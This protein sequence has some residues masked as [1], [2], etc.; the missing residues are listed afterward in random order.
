MNDLQSFYERLDAIP[1]TKWDSLA[2]KRIF[3]GHQSVGQN[4]I[5]GIKS[6]MDGYPAVR[7][8]IHQTSNPGDMGNAVFAHSPIGLN[9]DP[10]SKIDDFRT[11][12]ESGVGQIIDVAIFKFCFVDINRNTDVES[13]FNYYD[14]II[15]TLEHTYPRVRIITFTVPLTNMPTGIKPLIK[16]TLG[17]MPRY[18]EDNKKRNIFN[19]RLRTRFGKSVFDIA[20][21]EATLTEGKK[22]SFRDGNK[23]YDLLN[24]TYTSDGGH[25]NMLGRQIVAIDLLLYLLSVGAN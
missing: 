16:R 12:L 1:Q 10:K 8:N 11:I 6:V 22:A 21:A 3:F 19:E 15:T 23:T 20:E 13:L 24:L 14:K 4:I 17:V 18:K 2:A 5:D 9:M 7:L 25:L